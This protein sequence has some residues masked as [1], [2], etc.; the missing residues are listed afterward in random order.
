MTPT[1]LPC[2]WVMKAEALSVF[3]DALGKA[4][5]SREEDSQF[6]FTT[7]DGIATIPVCGPLTKNGLCFC[8]IQL[9]TGMRQ[10]GL[11][12]RTAAADP[13][14]RAILLDVDSP[15]GTVDGVEELAE[16]VNAVNAVKPVYAF[17]DGLMASGGYWLA[18]CAREIAAP[19]TAFVGSIGVIL[20]Q[21]DMS[22]ALDDMGVKYNI[23]TAGHYKAAGN[24]AE[25][26]SDEMRAY[27]QSGI[28]AVYELF[29]QA[30]A[31]GRGCSREAAL[32]MADGR[33]FLAEEA[34]RAG[35]IDRVCS[36]ESFIHYIK[37]QMT[38]TLAELKAQHAE[39]LQEYRAEVALELNAVYEARRAEAA[40][41]AE[42][43]GQEK[44]LALAES[45]LG[46]ESV[47]SIRELAACGVSPEQ[48]VA[49]RKLFTQTAVMQAQANDCQPKLDAM[50]TAHLPAS[51]LGAMPTEAAK[52]DFAELV[53]S[54]MKEHSASRGEAMKAVAVAHP[55][56][57]KLWLA[58]Q[59]KG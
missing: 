52:P 23:I 27:L 5:T 8:G 14:V 26:L 15:G 44:V 31:T 45:L 37:E 57:H 11:A 2:L 38:M 13:A 20:M 55:E 25:P 9:S 29:L 1:L 50:K 51:T 39:A 17:A 7:F 54:H 3:V 32:A 40:Q 34:R 4:S 16:T 56:E 48:A 12:L 43:A 21:R 35:L 28:D 24:S 30:V 47:A 59:Q 41:S 46:P 53:A 33:M 22:K 19:A 6:A 36:K 49:L 42:N 18:C 58:A 10:I